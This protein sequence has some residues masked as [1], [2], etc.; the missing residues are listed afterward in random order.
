MFTIEEDSGTVSG[1]SHGHNGY[2]AG[3]FSGSPLPTP[4]TLAALA[5]LRPDPPAQ[6]SSPRFLVR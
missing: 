1:T 3:D 6:T 2:Y 5:R 4:S